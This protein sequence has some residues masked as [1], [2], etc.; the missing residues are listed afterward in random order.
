MQHHSSI[1]LRWADLDAFGHINNAAYLV[2]VQEARADFT[3]YSRNRSG[4]EPIFDDM[5]V[6][7]AELDF[8]EPIYVGGVD[9]DV[10]IEVARIGNSSFEL[11]YLMSR[12]GVLHCKART[13]QVTV[14]MQTKKSRPLKDAEKIFLQ[15]YLV[16]SNLIDS[17]L[18]DSGLIDS[19]ENTK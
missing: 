16:E 19:G 15:K 13:V 11:S 5:V 10:V 1:Q 17:N 18:I 12:G 8:I 3:W 4:E 2:F 7:R 14:D 9:L 6:A